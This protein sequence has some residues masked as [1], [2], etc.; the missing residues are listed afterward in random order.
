MILI[1][2]TKRV[3]E[4]SICPV[5]ALIRHVDYFRVARDLGA[6]VSVAGVLEG[7]ACT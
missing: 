2:W 5:S 4:E 6:E 1:V 3:P 7:S